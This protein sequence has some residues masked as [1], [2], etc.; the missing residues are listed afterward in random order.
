[1]KDFVIRTL[2]DLLVSGAAGVCVWSWTH[3]HD[4]TA[5]AFVIVMFLNPPAEVA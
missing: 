4:L 2:R 5:T 3:N 1:M